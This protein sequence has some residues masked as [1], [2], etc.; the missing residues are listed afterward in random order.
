MTTIRYSQGA[1]GPSP[2]E[3]LY[4]GEQL[5][6]DL[7]RN[8]LCQMVAP[9]DPIRGTQNGQPVKFEENLQPGQV[10]LLTP[11]YRLP[12]VWQRHVTFHLQRFNKPFNW[13]YRQTPEWFIFVQPTIRGTRRPDLGGDL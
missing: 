13:Y 4:G 7:L 8:V 10:S 6:E 12:F 3:P 9:D 5:H 2:I 1:K 11:K